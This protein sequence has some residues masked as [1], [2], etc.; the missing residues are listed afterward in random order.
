LKSNLL[1]IGKV[2]LLA[3]QMLPKDLKFEHGGA[4]PNLFLSPG[5]I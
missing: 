2:V 5:A 1:K 3:K 4:K